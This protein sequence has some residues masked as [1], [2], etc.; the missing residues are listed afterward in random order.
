MQYKSLYVFQDLIDLSLRYGIQI[1]WFY[2]EAGQGRDL[3][4]AMAWFHVKGP[5][6]H[7]ILAEDRWF[8]TAADYLSTYFA[9]KEDYSKKCVLIDEEETANKRSKGKKGHPIKGS[10]ASHIISVKDGVATIRLSLHGSKEMFDLDF[11]AMAFDDSDSSDTDSD[12]EIDDNETVH[13]KETDIAVGQ[14]MEL[15]SVVFEAVTV[16]AII[17]LYTPSHVFEPFYLCKVYEV[18]IAE[19]S[20]TDPD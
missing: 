17:A 10:F 12:S 3:I 5:L 1:I 16:G 14:H 8:R 11:H 13:D 4:D 18:C 15:I 7:T 2:G 9:D 20:I 19:N 6:R